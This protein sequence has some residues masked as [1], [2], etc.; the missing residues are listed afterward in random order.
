M[1]KRQHVVN[2][3][4]PEAEAMR[5]A[6]DGK[7]KNAYQQTVHWQYFCEPQMYTYLRTVPQQVIP[8]ALWGRFSQHLKQW[9]IDHVGLIPTG[10]PNLHLMVNGCTLGLHSD[11][12]NG[13]WGFVFS[14]TRWDTRKFSGGETLLMRDGVP[15]YK[16]HHVQGEVLYEL[17]PAQFNQLLLF[18]DR[19][20]HGTQTIE[21]SM[22][23][24]EGRLALVG[25]LR[26]TSPVV[27][28]PLDAAAARKTVFEFHRA[29]AEP[30]KPYKDVQGVMTFRLGVGAD[31]AVESTTVLTDNF[32]TAHSGYEANEDVA[33]VRALVLEAAAKLHFAAASGPSK[34]TAAVLLPLPDLRP[35]EISIAHAGR[36][37]KLQESLKAQLKQGEAL[38][39]QVDVQGDGFAVRE[40][41]AG[42]IRIEPGRIV[43]SFD[44]PMWV[45]SQRDHFQAALSE[46][47]GMLAKY[48]G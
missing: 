1:I 22:D 39:F 23:P 45:P 44:P 21:G 20:V 8:E 43:A 12:H 28:G 36:P 34:V 5:T 15:S 30:V 10:A 9:C 31:G 26:A 4:F 17:V 37:A 32:V 41:L 33:A 40:P 27:A 48:G 3:F 46:N 13:T 19:I 14:L 38:G 24:L 42:T 16:K 47:L 25:H 18:D 29:L 6:Y 11:F 7:V 35:I 2:D